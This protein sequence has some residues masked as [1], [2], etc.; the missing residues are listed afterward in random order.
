MI[1]IGIG[2][3]ISIAIWIAIWIAIQ[4]MYPFTKCITLFIVKSLL[5]SN[6]PNLSG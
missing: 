1:K 4:K 5:H 2:I 6:L 3:K